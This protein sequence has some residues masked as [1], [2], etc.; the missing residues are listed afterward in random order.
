VGRGSGCSSKFGARTGRV[1][2]KAVYGQPVE[3]GWR[4]SVTILA[5]R[6]ECGV[7]RHRQ[8]EPQ[9]AQDGTDQ[10]FRL[11]QRRTENRAQPACCTDVPDGVGSQSVTLLRIS[12]SCRINTIPTVATTFR[13]RSDA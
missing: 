13:G 3:A 1:D 6:L 4:G 10:A 5:W 9:Q 7:I 8:I 11:A 2:A 12:P